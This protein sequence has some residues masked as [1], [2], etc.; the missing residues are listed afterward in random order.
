MARVEAGDPGTFANKVKGGVFGGVHFPFDF[1]LGSFE[2][3]SELKFD[4][5]VVAGGSRP[6]V[7]TET[8]RTFLLNHCLLMN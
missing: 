3:G 5:F 7:E 2:E 8:L 6:R 1:I 4:G